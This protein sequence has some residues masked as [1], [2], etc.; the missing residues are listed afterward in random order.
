MTNGFATLVTKTAFYNLPL[1]EY[2]ALQVAEAAHDRVDRMI[3]G[4]EEA[5]K[6]SFC[7]TKHDIQSGSSQQLCL[8]FRE[9]VI[10]HRILRKKD[11]LAGQTFC[12]Q[13]LNIAMEI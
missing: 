3:K 6:T 2:E 13:P 7:K 1:T 5:F 4:V 9:L 12:N 10:C 8:Y 11:I